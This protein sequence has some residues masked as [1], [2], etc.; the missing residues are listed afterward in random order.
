[1]AFLYCYYIWIPLTYNDGTDIE[2]KK[3][4][5]IR[6]AII[7]EFGGIT[8]TPIMGAPVYEGFMK[9]KKSKRMYRDKN[10]MFTVLTE[11]EKDV[12]SKNFFTKKMKLWKS[13]EW[14][15][16]ESFLI[17]LHQVQAL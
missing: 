11:A 3:L 2:P 1:M 4:F 17:I 6:D 8:M 16:Q 9:S 5:R 15:D 14:L 12:K 7:K 13:K 10:A